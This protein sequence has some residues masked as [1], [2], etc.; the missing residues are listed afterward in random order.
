ME[1][2]HLSTT[3]LSAS[4]INK[5]VSL[6]LL[7]DRSTSDSKLTTKATLIRDNRRLTLF[8]VGVQQHKFE[9]A[10]DSN[11]ERN[12]KEKEFRF[13]LRISSQTDGI[14]SAYN[15]SSRPMKEII[16]M[17]AQ[18]ALADGVE[19]CVQSHKLEMCLSY[20]NF[21]IHIMNLQ[22]TTHITAGCSCRQMM[23]VC[24]M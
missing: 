18:L 4:H 15:S 19:I 23:F 14:E 12:A 7:T 13:G 5:Y 1:M 20:L 3:Q 11:S 24:Q 22:F 10:K 2:D 9:E 6:S 8:A 16:M 21:W 17:T